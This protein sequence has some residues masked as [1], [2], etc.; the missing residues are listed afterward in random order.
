MSPEL[1]EILLEDN[2][3][4]KDNIVEMFKKSAIQFNDQ[5]LKVLQPKKIQDILRKFIG[6]KQFI[7]LINKYKSSTITSK[8]GIVI[9]FLMSVVVITKLLYNDIFE[10]TFKKISNLLFDMSKNLVG[11]LSLVKT[12]F[13]PTILVDAFKRD[14]SQSIITAIKNIPTNIGKETFSN[15]SLLNKTR[16]IKLAIPLMWRY[17]ILRKELTNVKKNF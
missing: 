17:R 7:A 10:K 15:M 13:K 9:L 11:L 16:S 3:T 6:E 1:K 12:G 5:I 2:I 8:V 4:I 14:D